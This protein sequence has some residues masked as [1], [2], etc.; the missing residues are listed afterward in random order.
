VE[1]RFVVSKVSSVSVFPEDATDPSK[2]LGTHLPVCMA[3]LSKNNNENFELDWL[4]KIPADMLLK[5]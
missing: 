1:V 5:M 3:T 4:T 2:I